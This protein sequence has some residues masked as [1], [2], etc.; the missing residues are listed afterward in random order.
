MKVDQNAQRIFIKYVC[1]GSADWKSKV[2][3][4]VE[5]EAENYMKALEY[6]KNIAESCQGIITETR[7]ERITPA[8]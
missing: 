8:P 2:Y 5:L 3:Y 6:C 7:I 4:A 1:A